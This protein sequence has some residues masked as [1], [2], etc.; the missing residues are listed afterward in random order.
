MHGRRG[1]SLFVNAL[2]VTGIMLSGV[3]VTGSAAI[4]PVAAGDAALQPASPALAVEVAESHAAANDKRKGGKRKDG[5]RGSPAAAEE[6]RARRAK[7]AQH[8]DGK[9]PRSPDG[10]SDRP[11]GRVGSWVDR[12][13]GP[14]AEKLHRSD[15]CT[16]GPDPAPPGFDVNKRVAPLSA[17]AAARSAATIACD[18]DGESGAR[19][20]VLYV[21]GA[22]RASRFDDYYSS[23]Q[24]WAGEMDQIFEDSAAETGESRGLRLVHDA[25]CNPTILEVQ[26]P[27]T[28][29][30]GFGAMITALENQG[31]NRSD[32]IYLSFVDTTT[33]GICGIG[34][35]W[36]DDRADGDVNWNNFG[37]SYS[38]VDAGC[39]DG[40]VAA[41][42]VM[43]N[44]GGVQ[45]SAPN[46]SGGFHC[47]DEYD[48]MCYSDSPRFPQ[49]RVDCPNGGLNATRFDCGDND[50]YN[51]DP[52]AGSY[53]AN[54]WNPANNRFLLGANDPPDRDDEAPAVEWVAP[55]G[56]DQTHR[57]SSGTVE[58]RANVTD[59]T[60]V[61]RVEFWRFD[62][63]D[64]EWVLISTDRSAPYRSSVNAAGLDPGLNVLSADGY[65]AAG[66]WT[67]EFIRLDVIPLDSTPPTVS[68]NL[69]ATVKAGNPAAIRATASDDVAV[70][71]VTF[72]FCS[73][74]SCAWPSAKKIGTDT[75]APFG[76]KW[77]APARGTF[78]FL[79]QAT[80][81]ASND[82][83][84]EAK[85][86]KVKPKSNKAKKRGR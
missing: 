83:V 73:G 44:L 80:D 67:F 45:L 22:N 34:T 49:M 48:I 64:Q 13:D 75:T 42:E 20:Q 17:R 38:R 10:R 59:D 36:N 58:L 53:L 5:T 16:H 14:A 37:P 61:D 72:A 3:L 65:D 25:G 56:N 1:V 26:I 82:A 11:S 74:T 63:D 40:W 6:R 81:E 31:F 23:L 41:H 4:V 71:S 60:G 54:H 76:V 47:I 46:T 39:W 28:S 50:Y 52:A 69:P 24:G 35:L 57:V 86:V 19:V 62:N 9:P 68:L 27:A 12:C 32:R 15:L 8:D 7:L 21:Y 2:M 43:H 18:G 84:S 78:T 29:V 66:N 85:I 70:A 51:A 55:V 33:A 30:N 79:A 77:Q